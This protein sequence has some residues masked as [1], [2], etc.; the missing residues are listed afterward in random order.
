MHVMMDWRFRGMCLNILTNVC[1]SSGSSWRNL[2]V[3]VFACAYVFLYLH[4]CVCV[5]VCVCVFLYLHV[6]VCVCTYFCICMCVCVCVCVH[7]IKCMYNS[8]NQRLHVVDKSYMYERAYL[9]DLTV[10]GTS[11]PS[12]FILSSVSLSIVGSILSCW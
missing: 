11:D 6:C 2:C 12:L 7:P 3:Y 9:R 5:C 8:V 4:V 10:S 1:N